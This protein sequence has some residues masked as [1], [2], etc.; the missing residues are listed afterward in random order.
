MIYYTHLLVEKAAIR[1]EETDANGGW[2]SIP[3]LI[4]YPIQPFLNHHSNHFTLKY[5]S[6]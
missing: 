3:F 1:G 6:L 4:S 2:H 5:N